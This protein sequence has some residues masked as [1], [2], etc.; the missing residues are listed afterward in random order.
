MVNEIFAMAVIGGVTCRLGPFRGRVVQMAANIET[1][2]VGH[3]ST[4]AGGEKSVKKFFWSTDLRI[5]GETV[6]GHGRPP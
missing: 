3:D 5:L 1:Q 4:I 6:R 2:E